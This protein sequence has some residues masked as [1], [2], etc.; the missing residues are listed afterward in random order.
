MRRT[1]LWLW[2]ALAGS[3]LQVVALFSNFYRVEGQ[4]RDAWFGIP[5][6]SDLILLSA[7]VTVG[8]LVL[9]AVGRNPIR[10]RNVG[11]AVGIAGLLATLQLGYRMII[12]PFG[13][14]MYS[15]GPS[16]AADVTL[17]WGIWVGLLGCVAVTVGGFVHAFSPTARDTGARSWAADTQ[18]GMSPWL[19]VAALAAVAQFVFGYTIFAF[20]T[21]R[22]FVGQEGPVSWG[23]WIATPHTS[24]FVLAITVIVVGL[25]VAAG[26]NRAPLKP[27]FLGGIIAVL[28]LAAGSRI[29]Y[30]IVVPPF[31]NAG[32]SSNVAVGTVSI[33]ASAY[34]SLIS[35]VVVIVAGLVYLATNRE[36]ATAEAPSRAR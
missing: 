23:G 19:G 2:V 12:P 33:H 20:Y 4:I 5:H 29:L 10:G 24:S 1:T 6:A 31:S 11:L 18:T 27:G 16:E 26:R 36:S 25:A 28:G 15:C 13:C 9:T 8:A 32:G 22:G 7:I 3:V 21:V 30:R 17:L 34:L 14:L 35:A